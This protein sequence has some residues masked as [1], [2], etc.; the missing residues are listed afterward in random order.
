M[1]KLIALFVC[2]F[3]AMTTVFAQEHLTFKGVSIDGTTSNFVKELETKGFVK[4]GVQ[5]GS[6]ILTG[7]FAGRDATVFTYS[8]P[9][10]K[11]VYRVCAMYEA[12]SKWSMVENV[13][14]DVKDMLTQKYGEPTSVTESANGYTNEY[15]DLL[16]ELHM[17]RLTWQSMWSVDKGIIYVKV[18]HDYSIGNVVIVGYEDKANSQDTNNEYLDDL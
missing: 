9:K 16:H 7:K 3:V 4:V 14:N 2:A 8:S 15:T 18:A 10:S 12:G 17:D 5:D 1:K 11:N 13:Y 6:A